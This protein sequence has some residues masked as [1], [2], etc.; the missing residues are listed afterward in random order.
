ML[1]KILNVADFIYSQKLGDQTWAWLDFF[2]N[3][4][5]DALK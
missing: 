2:F 4:I 1:E 3:G 5:K